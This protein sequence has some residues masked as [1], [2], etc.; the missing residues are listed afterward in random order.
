VGGRWITEGKL[1]NV[2]SKVRMWLV[3]WGTPRGAGKGAYTFILPANKRV[4]S[5]GTATAGIQPAKKTP[6]GRDREWLL[7]NHTKNKTPQNPP[8]P[9]KKKTQEK[10]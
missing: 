10:E 6:Y 1:P 7:K 3:T 8:P 4:R 2:C 9:T 5:K